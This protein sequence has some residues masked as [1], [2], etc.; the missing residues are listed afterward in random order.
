MAPI[1]FKALQGHAFAELLKRSTDEH[2]KFL[3]SSQ[4]AH[5]I[6]HV[7]RELSVSDPSFLRAFLPKPFVDLLLTEFEVFADLDPLPARRH[8]ALVLL[9]KEL[10]DCSFSGLKAKPR[11]LPILYFTIAFAH[12]IWSRLRQCHRPCLSVTW[13]YLRTSAAILFIQP[14]VLRYHS[15][16]LTR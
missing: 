14:D 8:G 5:I 11:V 10:K 16:H 7:L 1:S 15:A 12:V 4:C 3:L 13:I 9:E 6:D 2:F